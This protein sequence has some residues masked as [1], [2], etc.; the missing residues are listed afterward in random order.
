MDAGKHLDEGGLARPVLAAEGVY[1]PGL[2]VEADLAEGRHSRE[3]LGDAARGEAG[4]QL[5]ATSALLW[6]PSS[7]TVD[8]MFSLVTVWTSSSMEG[9]L[10]LPLS[11]VCVATTGLPVAMRKAVSA[12]LPARDL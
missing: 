2:E 5:P 9:T 6:K 7:T 3:G 10:I 4:H 12:A 11:T 1:L 8:S